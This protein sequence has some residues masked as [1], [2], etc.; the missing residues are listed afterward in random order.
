MRYV[1]QDSFS[2]SRRT[3]AGI[4]NGAS[5]VKGMVR[6]DS[7][8]YIVVNYQESQL[9]DSI[10]VL[11]VDMRS[12]TILYQVQIYSHYEDIQ[13]THI[14]VAGLSL[15]LACTVRYTSNITQVLALSVNRELSF[16]QLPPGFVRYENKTFVGEPIA[17]KRTFLTMSTKTFDRTAEE[18]TFNPAQEKP[19]LRPSVA[20]TQLPSSEPSSAPSGQPSSS[21]TSAPSIS[22]QPTS[23]PSSSGPTN[24]YKPTVKPTQQPTARSTVAPSAQPTRNPSA[25]STARPSLSPR[26]RPSTKPSASP[27]SNKPNP[28]LSVR[29]TKSPT[30][31]SSNH[32][33]TASSAAL[34]MVGT[35][36]KESKSYRPRESLILGQCVAG[37]CLLWILY[38]FYR[39][40]IYKVKEVKKDK[41]RVREMIA[42]DLPGKARHPI[43]SATA[44][45]CYSMSVVESEEDTNEAEMTCVF[46]PT[47]ASSA[48]TGN[49]TG[50]GAYIEGLEKFVDLESNMAQNTP[51]FK[52]NVFSNAEQ[53][54]GLDAAQ[55]VAF[56]D[57]EA[58][59]GR[60]TSDFSAHDFDS[61]SDEDAADEDVDVVLSEVSDESKYDS[62]RSC[63]SE[64]SQNEPGDDS[65][66]VYTIS[67]DEETIV[68][69]SEENN[70]TYVN[71]DRAQNSVDALSNWDCE[72]DER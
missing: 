38:Q 62:E 23:H 2:E 39:W 25:S 61:E 52:L 55:T 50:Q 72:V 64:E 67:S 11:K 20:P 56:L 33:T 8:L 9:Q 13:C 51:S 30:A 5:A 54:V 22:P 32:P 34:T 10:S 70:I 18:Y 12:G 36:R 4:V 57:K 29:P 14:A 6:V 15:V 58:T 69:R 48:A 63:G 66:V 65:D 16:S 59:G 1:Q 19:T 24:T 41:K 28:P 40:W 71:S 42:Q 17:F 43:F 37:L 68:R 45:L 49:Y 44:G 21:P 3:Q 47:A 35:D 60:E 27:S 53:P 46:V 7:Y 31:L 26:V